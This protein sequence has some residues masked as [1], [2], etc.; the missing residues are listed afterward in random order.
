[1]TSSYRATEGIIEHSATVFFLEGGPQ[2]PALII[3]F[4]GYD[5]EKRLLQPVAD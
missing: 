4:E 2:V 1:M 3:E 5:A